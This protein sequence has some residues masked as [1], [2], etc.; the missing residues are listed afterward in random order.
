[1]IYRVVRLSN[2]EGV[3]SHFLVVFPYL[4]VARAPKVVILQNHQKMGDN[5]GKKVDR[6]KKTR[7]PSLS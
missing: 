1:M 2:F 4:S 6:Y 5:Y 7:L 3:N